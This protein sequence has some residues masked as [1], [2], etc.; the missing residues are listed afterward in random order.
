MT[1]ILPKAF[2]FGRAMIMLTKPSLS[3]GP[4]AQDEP[5]GKAFFA[6]LGGLLEKWRRLPRDYRHKT[7]PA[8]RRF[9]FW[10]ETAYDPESLG[11]ATR[12]AC[13]LEGAG[14]LR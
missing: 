2:A 6:F 3:W 5:H 8:R 11:A 13:D 10:K 9:S 1:P 4:Q 14:C 12:Q 7:V